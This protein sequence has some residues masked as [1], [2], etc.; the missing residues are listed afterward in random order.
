[1]SEKPI[2][3]EL[4]AEILLVDDDAIILLFLRKQLQN[5]GYQHI[6]SCE[7]PKQAV[8]LLKERS[9]DLLLL[10]Q[11]MPG[12]SGIELLEWLQ[13]EPSATKM[14]VMMLTADDDHEA[15]HKALSSGAWDFVTKPFDTV[16]VMSRVHNMVKL[17]TLH[18]GLQQSNYQLE[19]K[20][21]ERTKQL[22]REVKERGRVEKQLEHLSVID[23][24]TGLPSEMIFLDRLQQSLLQGARK[25]KES[26]VIWVQ[27]KL[28]APLPSIKEVAS[29]LL[30]IT[31]NGSLAR[32]G[33]SAFLLLA[34][35]LDSEGLDLKI[36]LSRVRNAL[37]GI[38]VKI[39]SAMSSS[40]EVDVET[41]IATAR[42]N[43][44]SNKMTTTKVVSVK[45]LLYQAIFGSKC[46]K[47]NLVWQPQFSLTEQKVTGAEVL[48]RWSSLE[49]G[50]VSPAEIVELAER[51]GWI[52]E[53]TRWV[54]RNTIK[55]VKDWRDAGLVLDHCSINLSAQDLTSLDTVP[56]IKQQLDK[57][58]LP[59]S[60][61]CV[62]I[63]ETELMENIELGRAHLEQL[64]ALGVKVALD[65]FG[66][67]YSSLSYLRL[68]PIDIIKIDRSF[69]I[70]LEE[71]AASQA[72][73]AGIVEMARMLKLQ[74]VVEGVE[75]QQQL[76][77][78]LPYSVEWI[79]GYF[80]SKPLQKEEFL[81]Y[82]S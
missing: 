40:D 70:D 41:L 66:T 19:E 58:A 54:I 78:L 53:I 69:V 55:Q 76:D 18:K 36:V 79:Q 21:K 62:E 81:N 43:L 74:I 5:S 77:R 50:K 22:R 31:R 68:F 63:T 20:V 44:L 37:N 29:R 17:R 24:L 60:A 80:Y 46:A 28:Q 34:S 12:M 23:Q 42:E 16:E 45:A 11:N 48:L 1:M 75:Y 26:G 27:L 47:F 25:G 39:G 10:D 82:C 49:L 7:D 65:D 6:T 4:D 35:D 32:R 64:R 59:P 71:S 56:Y 57:F 3:D 30:P 73:V 33:R 51:E 61:L 13:S 72:V 9:F 52:T 14:P 67:G 2:L 15:R 38:E 8:K